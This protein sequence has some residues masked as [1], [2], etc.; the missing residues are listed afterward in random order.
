LLKSALAVES[1]TGQFYRRMTSELD[2]QGRALFE[3]FVEI[4]DGHYAIV[5]AQ[6]D[7]LSG[8]GYWFDFMEFDL[9]AG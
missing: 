6:I 7:A 8:F 1:E 5:Q 4:E 9:E 3:P 2:E